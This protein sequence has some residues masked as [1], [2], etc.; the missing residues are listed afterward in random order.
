MS[1]S[2]SC[3]RALSDKTYEK[4]KLAAFEIEK[5]EK[6]WKT[7]KISLNFVFFRMVCEFNKTKNYVQIRK[8]IETFASQYCTSKD[9][10]KRK[11][12]LIAIGELKLRNFHWISLNHFQPLAVSL[13][14]HKIV[15][16]LS[17]NSS[18]PC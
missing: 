15:F 18:H 3:A 4:R 10:N 2:E 8:L 11:G 17:M 6:A 9:S 13:S 14:D 12:G 5:W 16:N 7:L 1:L